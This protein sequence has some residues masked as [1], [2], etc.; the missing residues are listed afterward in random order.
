M[1]YSLASRQRLAL[2]GLGL[3][4]CAAPAAAN[5]PPHPQ[6]KVDW[7]FKIDVHLEHPYLHNLAPW[8]TYFPQDDHLMAQGPRP[9]FYPTWPQPFPPG[10]NDSAPMSL[11]Q[12]QRPRGPIVYQH[13]PF[14]PS[15]RTFSSWVQPVSYYSNQ[16]P[17]YWF[18]R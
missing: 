14:T 9:S 15:A 1:A 2:A 10:S 3:L 12:A 16:A 13:R 7:T 18:G 8:W 4:L 17:S 11:P 5:Y 6:L